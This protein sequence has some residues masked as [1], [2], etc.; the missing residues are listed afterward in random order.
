MQEE[1]DPKPSIC[2]R[3]SAPHTHPSQI[4]NEKS[5]RTSLTRRIETFFTKYIITYH[6]LAANNMHLHPSR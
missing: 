1:I 6:R 3:I 4:L 2:T 5:E